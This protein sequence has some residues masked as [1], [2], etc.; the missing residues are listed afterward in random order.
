MYS[1]VPL[2]FV[3]TSAAYTD[4]WLSSGRLALRARSTLEKFGLVEKFVRGL[5]LVCVGTGG[6][7]L[8]DVVEALDVVLV[9]LETVVVRVA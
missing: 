4:D 1:V 2:E 8:V 9:G 3:L 5:K 6:D 7:C